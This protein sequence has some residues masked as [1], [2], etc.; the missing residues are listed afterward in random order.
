MAQEQYSSREERLAIQEYA[1]KEVCL[2]VEVYT[3]NEV[4]LEKEVGMAR[5]LCL[6]MVS[7]RILPSSPTSPIPL[8]HGLFI[9]NHSPRREAL[10]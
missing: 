5:D 9:S 4:H 6:A 8:H 10:E 7:R 1:V 2:A 3:E